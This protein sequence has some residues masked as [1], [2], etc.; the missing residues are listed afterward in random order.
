[1]LSPAY[2]GNWK[3]IPRYKIQR[4]LKYIVVSCILVICFIPGASAA[5]P[6]TYRHEHF[7]FQLDP[8]VYSWSGPSDQWVYNGQPVRPLSEWRVDGDEVPPLPAG[9]GQGSV[10]TWRR[11]EITQTIREKISSVINREPGSVVIKRNA[12]GSIMFEGVGLTGR[13]VKIEEAVDLT[14]YALEHGLLDITLPVAETQPEINVQDAE[15]VSAGIQEV[16]T[17]GES[18]FAGSPNNRRHNIATGISKFNGHLI[19]QGEIFSFNKVLGPVEAATGFKLELVILGDRVEPQYGGGL[20]QISTTAYR[21]IWEY[22]FPIEQRRNHSFAVQYYAPQGTDA[23]IYPPHTD[24]KFKNDSPGDLLIQTHVEG[25]NAYYIFYGTRDDRKIE[26]IGPY[27]WGHAGPPADRIEYTTALPP[28]VTK[29]LGSQV[30]GM[31]AA[32]FRVLSDTPTQKAS[33][34]GEFIESVYSAYQSRPLF[35]QVGIA[36]PLPEPASPTWL[37]EAFT[38]E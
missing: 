24:M 34:T 6:I 4:V 33:G 21:G 38:V 26:V 35:L 31:R 30:S 22:G 13:Q 18:N 23:T 16:V 36:G 7:I 37:G 3:K 32:W 14:L 28:G 25:D 12:S 10:T 11:T 8:D 27:T 2:L 1:M 5:A 9:V 29:K 17:I 19:P 15:L 20:C